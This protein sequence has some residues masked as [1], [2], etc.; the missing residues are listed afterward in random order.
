MRMREFQSSCLT[1]GEEGRPPTSDSYTLQTR[2]SLLEDIA[3]GLRSAESNDR[4]TCSG[5]RLRWGGEE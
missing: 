1:G 5:I 3:M 4:G 2:R